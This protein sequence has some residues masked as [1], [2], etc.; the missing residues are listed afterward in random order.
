MPEIR[1]DRAPNQQVPGAGAVSP[2][3][4]MRSA[5]S[6]ACVMLLAIFSQNVDSRPVTLDQSVPAAALTPAWITYH[7]DNARSGNDTTEGVVSGASA[8]WTAKTASGSTVLDGQVYAS[9]LVYGTSVYVV[10][11]NNTVY[12]FNTATGVEQW[13]RHLTGPRAA[14][15]LPCGNISPNVGIT[16]TPVIDTNAAGGHG[17]IFVAAMTYE[18]HYRL[19][20][21]DLVTHAVTFNTVIDRMHIAV[22]GQRGALVLAN[23]NVYVPFGGRAGDCYDTDG[24][25]YYGIVVGVPESG[26]AHFSWIAAGTTPSS[27]TE[28]A[29]IWA[30]GGE[31]VDASG[32]VYV[33]LGNG[34]GPGTESVFKLS[35]TLTVVNQW[36]ASNFQALD[37]ADQDVGSIIP[38]LIGGGDVFQ[39]GKSGQ[40]FVLDSS[41]AQQTV[42]PGLTA[43]GGQSTDASFGAIAYASPY[44]YVPCANGLYAYSQSGHV[45]TP[46][47]NML[48]GFAG[49]PIV[50]GGNVWT[51]S[52]GNLYGFDA[53]TGAQ[54]ANISV[55]SFSRFESPAA[56]GGRIFVATTSG[57][58]AYYLLH[59]RCATA[60]I[61][62]TS[63]NQEA[64]T[65]I[66][67][68]AGSTGCPDA[69]YAYWL[70]YPNGKWYIRRT[71]STD[72]AYSFNSNSFK[73]GAYVMRVW[74][75][76]YPSAT[77]YE[78]FAETTVTLTGCT[79][80]TLS[81][82]SG[83]VSVATPVQFTANATGC[84]IP[85]YEFWVLDT[86]GKWHQMTG[87]GGPTWTWNHAGWAK[88]VYHIRAWANQ[89]GAYTGTYEVFGA[90]TYT[91]T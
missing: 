14:S 66:A 53:A 70:K 15:A 30:P 71:F 49:P 22:E 62:P 17:V 12:A 5:V 55:G 28:A 37:N 27:F 80:A 38:G 72:P 4:R 52:Q 81:P 57:L 32:N 90:S 54:I 87:F 20:G 42:D 36:R 84:T 47:W 86:V 83:S 44:V 45:L 1:S 35:P 41:L 6:L 16:S 63:P 73:P 77:K 91:L 56:G 21:V 82:P 60:S 7:R 61:S 85:R 19:V 69:H 31:S 50:A 75:N 2:A 64:G 88:G 51:Q 76:Q 78:T 10:T 67:F 58:K 40:A 74:A 43:C 34:V 59:P 13:H 48:S 3:R 18:P 79:A 29:G 46:A 24:T 68:T 25:P 8:A 23:G 89:Q 33:A 26:A 9:P 39:N 11:E 65:T